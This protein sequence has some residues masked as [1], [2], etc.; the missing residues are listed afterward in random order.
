MKDKLLGSSSSSED[1]SIEDLNA[2]IE[3]KEK[4]V[5]EEKGRQ[6]LENLKKEKKQALKSREKEL[7]KEKFRQ[8][9]SGKLLDNVGNALDDLA[10][11]V[12]GSSEGEKKA[13][14]DLL[15]ISD[16]LEAVDGDG[17]KD[18]QRLSRLFGSVEKPIKEDDVL[19]TVEVDGTIQLEDDESRGSSS[20]RK[21][22]FGDDI[23][24]D[25]DMGF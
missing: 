19:G 13:K 9:R 1:E 17:R 7:Q 4:Q 12:D 8:T 2:R 15:Q 10:N 18:N 5:L 24:M 21:S 6:Q 20:K 3:E 23:D 14:Q 25:V 11:E 16:N 22:G